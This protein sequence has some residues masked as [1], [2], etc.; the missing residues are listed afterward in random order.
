MNSNIINQKTEIP[1][2]LPE[3]RGFLTSNKINKEPIYLYLPEEQYQILKYSLK[4]KD[5]HIITEKNNITKLIED[6][7]E[8][9]EIFFKSYPLSRR[10]AISHQEPMKK[11]KPCYSFILKPDEE[12]KTKYKIE[13]YTKSF[14][15]I[16]EH[17]LKFDNKLK[18]VYSLKI[19]ANLFSKG[20]SDK[21][22]PKIFEKLQSISKEE[23]LLNSGSSQKLIEIKKNKKPYKKI[24]KELFTSRL[25]DF[26]EDIVEYCLDNTK[27]MRKD[28][29]EN[30]ICFIEFF[31]LLFCGIKTKYYIDELSYINMDFYSDE[32]NMM[33]FAESFH[34]Q[35]QF[36]IKDIPFLA[37]YGKKKKNTD[38]TAKERLKIIKK[39]YETLFL[40][41]QEKVPSLDQE[42]VEYYP[43][44]CDF[45]RTISPGFR[46]Y[47][48]ND[49][50]H[51]CEKCK[52]IPNSEV[53]KKLECSSCFRQI[54][55]ERLICLNLSHIMNFNKMKELC[56]VN[57]Y[58]EEKIFMDKIII[59][60]YEGINN[61]ITTREIMS[62]YLVPF[63]TKEIVK[64]DK[65][66]RDI[67]GENVGFYFVWISHFTKWLFYLAIIGIFMSILSFF[68]N[69]NSNKHIYL[70][71][72]LMFIA[73]IIL[74]GN[75]YYKSWDGQESFYNYIWGMND[76]IL[77]QNSIYDFEEHLKLNVEIIMGVKIPIEKPLT[78][79]LINFFLFFLS[80]FLHILVI[81]SNI[82]IIESKSYKF[83]I[84][85]KNIE[86][87]LNKIWKYIVPVLCYILREI[88]SF[89][90]EKWDRWIINHGK[91]FSKEIKRQIKLRMRI[92]FEFF[93]YYFNLYYIAF[94]KKY[95]GTCLD[96]D[97]HNELGNQLI[98]IIICDLVVMIL[99]LLIPVYFNYKQRKEI[100]K[101]IKEID[102]GENASSKYKYYSRNKFLF[103]DMRSNYI[104]AIL[105]FGYLI[106]FGAS[107]PMIFALILLVSII[108]RIVL[109]MALKNIY[110]AQVFEESVGIL[111]LKKWIR[112]ISFFGV[113][114]NLCC[115]FYTN[116]YF[117][118]LS[119]K[120]KLIYMALIEN[121]LL[122]IIKIFDYDSLPR[123]F[124][125][126]DK[127]DFTYLRKFGIRAKKFN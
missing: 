63:E 47:D 67:Y 60:N 120:R 73:A 81:I 123:W 9:F 124:Y 8:F 10:I 85:N 43:T 5:Y 82:L 48:E 1:Y 75:Y 34:Y 109:G 41:N 66:F 36:R 91:Q 2:P 83:H 38:L 84:K 106:Q 74:W 33:N 58:D 70:I 54:D 40:L 68:I 29:L 14:P 17:I 95:L 44:H 110:F 7:G 72:N 49:D 42:R 90:G 101:K 113:I 117:Y 77:V 24:L 22:F 114:S 108:N 94:I 18:R 97:C 53:C 26:R 35:V 107:A 19:I 93:N 100:D 50:Y 127:I 71:I 11:I 99:S 51:I 102:A 25:N 59:P 105:Y 46:R 21:K 87:Y 37:P 119:N 88:F 125:F 56:D 39:K 69:E 121:I 112:I 89:V 16:R 32:K 45:S 3:L 52:Y 78:Y 30:F 6:I 55:K 4:I 80:I 64:L 118:W 20:D 104:K 31:A 86:N 122:V 115:I 23:D 57:I 28:N 116:N 103:K 61:R 98:V 79:L 111:K 62:N 27:Y 15:K 12:F 92:V 13:E 76:Y 65:T 96:G 126:K